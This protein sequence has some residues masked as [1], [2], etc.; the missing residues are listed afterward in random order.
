MSIWSKVAH[1]YHAGAVACTQQ[2]LCVSLH[3]EACSHAI[4]PHIGFLRRFLDMVDLALNEQPK[5]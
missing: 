1:N 2:H 4:D 3:V 5:E